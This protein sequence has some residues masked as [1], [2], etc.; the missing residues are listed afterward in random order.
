MHHTSHIV[1]FKLILHPLLQ[2]KP[3][4][5]KMGE[6]A[7]RVPLQT[8]SA[9]GQH[10]SIEGV[11]G[12]LSDH[13]LRIAVK[14]SLHIIV[15][16]D[17]RLRM[18][19]VPPVQFQKF[20][21][22]LS[23]R[24]LMQSLQKCRQGVQRRLR[25]RCHFPCLQNLQLR[26]H[27]PEAADQI[28][29]HQALALRVRPAVGKIQLLRRLGQ[30]QIKIKPLHIHFFPGS[31]RQ[32]RLI[33]L[34]FL[35]V[36]LR[37]NSSGTGM[38][39]NQSLIDADKKQY[40]DIFQ[41]GS[42]IVSDQHLIRRRRDHR[43]LCLL[44]SCFQNFLIIRKRNRLVSQHLHKFV[45]QLHDDPVNLGIFP[46]H[47]RFSTVLE[48]F[49][50]PFQLPL[51]VAFH[52]KFIEGFRLEKNRRPALLHSLGKRLHFLQKTAA[53]FIDMQQFLRFHTP[54]TPGPCFPVPLKSPDSKGNH[55]IFQFVRLLP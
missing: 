18:V 6:R 22:G 12:G 23:F 19:F 52:D 45:Q 27:L 9:V 51:T 54:V 43:H 2:P 37:E 20:R 50:L 53:Q 30:I 29:R 32:F 13:I 36:R 38:P 34:Q 39:W 55:I 47:R 11:G 42:L 49:F 33:S 21:S 4:L 35:P 3:I 28:G 41:P 10:L 15:R 1:R 48:H 40:P 14:N 5:H 26:K 7:C 17:S 8:G 25:T 44:E 31:G 46:C 16:R 24:R